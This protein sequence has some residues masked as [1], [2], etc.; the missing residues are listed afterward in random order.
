MGV[1][2]LVFHVLP[3]LHPLQSLAFMVA[4]SLLPAAAALLSALRAAR[5]VPALTSTVALLL[6]GSSVGLCVV[7]VFLPNSH[8]GL[9][10]A[11]RDEELTVRSADAAVLYARAAACAVLVSTRWLGNYW[12]AGAGQTRSGCMGG[13]RQDDVGC[14]V[15]MSGDLSEEALY[16]PTSEGKRDEKSRAVLSLWLS[17]VR[18]VVGVVYGVAYGFVQDSLE[19]LLTS[20]DDAA[21]PLCSSSATT[22]TTT[23]MTAAATLTAGSVVT[24]NASLPLSINS[25]TPP[26][27]SATLTTVASSGGVPLCNS[28]SDVPEDFWTRYGCSVVQVL[29]CALCYHL[30]VTSCRLRMQRTSFSLPLTLAPAVTFA[31]LALCPEWAVVRAWPTAMTS[32]ELPETSLR[33]WMTLAAF[34]AGWVSNVVLA[35]HIFTRIPPERLMFTERSVKRLSFSHDPNIENVKKNAVY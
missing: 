33:W 24:A 9:K 8:V 5:A 30:A 19:V 35:S 34:L 29:S 16:R 6:Q 26:T 13:A 14:S 23:S 20:G 12:E 31:L 3:C 21:T 25:T 18:L 2:T 4:L 17:V 10:S 27:A 22:A 32:A 11:P 15:S 28:G 1:F 7:F